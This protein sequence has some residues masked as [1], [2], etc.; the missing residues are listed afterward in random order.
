MCEGAA[1]QLLDSQCF[2]PVEPEDTQCEKPVEPEEQAPKT[3]D[4]VLP[5]FPAA[6]EPQPSPSKGAVVAP[7]CCLC[8]KPMPKAV[9]LSRFGKRHCLLCAATNTMAA[10]ERAARSGRLS[11]EVAK[12]SL[13]EVLVRKRVREEEHALGGPFLPLK[14]WLQQGY[15]EA[16][17]LAG[18]YEWSPQLGHTYQVQVHTA[19]ER[20][21]HTE[22]RKLLLQRESLCSQRKGTKRKAEVEPQALEQEPA[23]DVPVVSA[24]PSSTVEQSSSTKLSKAEA[25]AAKEEQKKQDKLTKAAQK[26]S[27]SLLAAATKNLPVVRQTEERLR[28]AT[29]Q[30]E[31]VLGE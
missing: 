19:V 20:D 1:T 3:P 22:V 14:V 5:Q 29:S 27:E 9:D 23:W 7:T 24:A 13:E 17:V 31:V 30:A 16:Q 2:K 4:A 21:L 28:K 11:W 12:A 15:E 8:G 6:V 18:N 26:A 10:V 25:K